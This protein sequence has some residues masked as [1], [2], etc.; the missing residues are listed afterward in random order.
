M[1]QTD[2]LKRL[3]DQLEG[4]Q[5]FPVEQWDPPFC[6]DI[7][8]RIDGEGRWWYKDNPI[9]RPELVKLFAAILKREGDDYMLVTPVEKVRIQV[10]D[11]PFVFTRYRLLEDKGLKWLALE[12]ETGDHVIV[13]PEHP[14][15]LRQRPGEDVELP[16]VEVRSSLWGVPG[17]ALY[18]RMV[19]K[20]VVEREVPGEGA[21]WGVES[22]GVFYPLSRADQTR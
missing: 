3:Y 5:V 18:Y 7:E 13:S 12:A 9:E 8:I 14:L 20:L 11:V 1:S 4:R 17:R 19:D 2:A 22:G 15:V 6:G 16:Y 21:I 10:K